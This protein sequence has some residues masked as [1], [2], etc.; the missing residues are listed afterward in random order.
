MWS[1][2]L[3]RDI[4]SVPGVS[5]PDPLTDRDYHGSCG[6]FGF[7]GARGGRAGEKSR[8]SSSPST[9]LS[10]EDG[11]APPELPNSNNSL[12]REEGQLLASGVTQRARD[13]P[14]PEEQ[15]RDSPPIPQ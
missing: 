11:R 1:K 9:W 3:G 7:P 4:G 6:A 13:R 10:S 12:N 8:E 5:L 14:W 2:D 15:A